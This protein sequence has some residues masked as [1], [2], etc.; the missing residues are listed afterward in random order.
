ML[1]IVGRD[2]SFGD[3]C[4]LFSA[5]V[6]HAVVLTWQLGIQLHSPRVISDA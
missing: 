1:E 4:G 3:G 2:A 6:Q 5:I